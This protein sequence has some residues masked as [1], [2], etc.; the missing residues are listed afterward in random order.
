MCKGR[1]EK[2]RKIIGTREYTLCDRVRDDETARSGFIRLAKAVFGLDF[3]RWHAGGWWG[4]DYIP[5]ALL[6]GGRVVANVSANLIRTRAKGADKVFVQIGTVM[7]DPEYRGRGLARGLM[8]EVMARYGGHCDGMYLYANDTVLGFYPKFGFQRA[9][10]HA[11]SLPVRKSGETVRRL[12]MDDP[13]DRSRLLEAYL[14]RSNPHSALPMLGNTGLLMFYCGQFLS[15]QV[16]E[17]PGMDAVAVAEYQG[18]RMLVRDVFGGGATLP[19]IL[20]ALAAEETQTCALGFTPLLAEG[21]VAELRVEEDT[22][23]FVTGELPA[24]FS[25]NKAMFPLL[26]HA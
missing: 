25:E 24:L 17:I 1:V 21:M 22:T 2:M 26:S 11:H 12:D 4:G 6:D 19:E 18:G 13:K 9:Q 23:L 14:A 16:Y 20:N 8:E 3:T 7:T 15:H 10:E 5:H